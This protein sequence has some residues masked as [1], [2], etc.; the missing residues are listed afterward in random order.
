M[1]TATILPFPGSVP[2]RAGGDTWASSELLACGD[3]LEFAAGMFRVHRYRTGFRL[4][5]CNGA[6]KRGAR[7][8][9][10]AFDTDI[11]P[12][13][14]GAGLTAWVTWLAALPLA[15]SY[16]EAREWAQV[17]G[18]VGYDSTLRGVDVQPV[19]LAPVIV[20]GPLCS[21]CVDHREATGADKSDPWNQPRALTRN[22]NAATATKAR[23]VLEAARSDIE[24]G[25]L[26]FYDVVRLLCDAGFDMHT[27]CSV[28]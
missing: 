24:L 20:D 3:D 28:D 19:G 9:E 14:D 26:R 10:F 11:G 13:H 4:T 16:R 15:G 25:R 21:F 1:Q 23:A 5:D 18:I 7:L 17:Y 6:G 2:F 27:W 8:G 12:N 22:P